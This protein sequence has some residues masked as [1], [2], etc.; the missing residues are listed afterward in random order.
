MRR[1][2]VLA[3]L[4]WVGAACEPASSEQAGAG[5]A[6]AVSA[7]SR[8]VAD[9]GTSAL[10][11]T[12]PYQYSYSP[13]GKRDPFRNQAA[14]VVDP[15][16]VG[17]VV[18]GQGGCDEVL[19]Q[20]DLGELKLVAVVSGDAN[21]VAMVEDRNG[22]GHVLR[23]NTKVGRQAGKVTAILRDCVVV[24]SFVNGPDGRQ[25]PNRQSLCVSPE[26]GTSPVFDLLNG[27]SRD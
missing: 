27:K 10:T 22:V 13:I 1:W 4:V 18:S 21:P 5:A 26:G 11:V 23:R 6:P 16:P 20:Y 15:G 8:G 17:P 12:E 9:A 24:T 25:Q 19:C 3:L 7:R 2:F 14:L